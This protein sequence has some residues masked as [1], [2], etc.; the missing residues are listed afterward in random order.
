M[1]TQL[2][3]QMIDDTRQGK[4]ARRWL[5]QGLHISIVQRPNAYTLIISRD[6]VYPSEQEWETVLKHWPYHV[7]IIQPSKIVDSDRHMALKADLPTCLPCN[8]Q[9]EPH[10]SL[11]AQASAQAEAEA[12][13]QAGQAGAGIPTARATQG[14]L[15]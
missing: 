1:L 9:A 8:R 6:T 15:L 2:I 7:E 12:G 11:L 3:N 10:L 5:K 4:P 14:K 13:A